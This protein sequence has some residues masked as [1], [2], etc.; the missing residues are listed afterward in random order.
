MFFLSPHLTLINSHP[1]LVRWA[2]YAIT[3]DL[4]GPVQSAVVKGRLSPNMC[5]RPLYNVSQLALNQCLL[6]LSQLRGNNVQN[7]LIM[8]SRRFVKSLDC[9]ERT[10]FVKTTNSSNVNP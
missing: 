2:N 4:V 10:V 5:L 3:R 9:F 8:Q 6:S 1:G 7:C